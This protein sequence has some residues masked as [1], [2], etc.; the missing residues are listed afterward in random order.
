MQFCEAVSFVPFWDRIGYDLKAMT[1]S[2]LISYSSSWNKKPY[3][4]CP[5][6]EEINNNTDEVP[7]QWFLSGSKE[8]EW[9]KTF[10]S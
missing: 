2:T 4:S 6:C 5:S 9:Y 1:L 8:W 3:L 10:P 7:I